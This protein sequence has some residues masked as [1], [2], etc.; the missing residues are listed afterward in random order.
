[1]GIERATAGD[2]AAIHVLLEDS[3][4]PVSDLGP[5][6]LE[7][8]LVL[9][10]RGKLV[11]VG[12]L[13]WAGGDVLL[14]S[15]AVAP[16]RRSGGAGKALVAAL[17]DEARRR[18]ARAIHLLTTTAERYFAG[19]GYGIAPRESAPAGIRGTAQF[20]GLCPASSAFMVKILEPA[21]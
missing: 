8:F 10:E 20:A 2:A 19:L 4:L 14:R 9:R 15:L 17:E 16:A 13:E 1:M 6:L 3:G 18:G 11:A 7:S 12:A 21:A 5:A